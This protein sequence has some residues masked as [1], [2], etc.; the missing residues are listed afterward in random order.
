MFGKLNPVFENPSQKLHKEHETRNTRV[1]EYLRKYG[2][3]KIDSMPTDTR[4]QVNDP[5]S[6][7]EMLND[8]D[9]LT[10]SLSPEQLDVLLEM[11]NNTAE[12]EAAINDIKLT[13]KQRQKFDAARKVLNDKNASYEQILDA[14]R[15]IEELRESHKLTRARK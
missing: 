14:H 12:F 15:I 3:G 5:R 10:S 1:S 11:Q 2:Q 7:E 13:E 9:K 4:P 8:V 6:V